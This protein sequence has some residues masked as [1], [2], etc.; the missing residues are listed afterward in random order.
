MFRMFG[1][2]LVFCGGTEMWLLIF[3]FSSRIFLKLFNRSLCLFAFCFLRGPS[4][5]VYINITGVS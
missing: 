5:T 2:F 1:L 3:S 4:H